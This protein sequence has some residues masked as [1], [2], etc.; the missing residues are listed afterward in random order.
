MVY[1]S[2]TLYL[3]L[4]AALLM[5]VVLFDAERLL[6]DTPEELR[7]RPAWYALILIGFVKETTIPFLL[8][9]LLCRLAGR[10]RGLRIALRSGRTL[11]AEAGVV[12]GVLFPL[13]AYLFFRELWAESSAYV[14]V[15][16]HLLDPRNYTILLRSYAQ[17][18]GPLGLL[19][20]GGLIVMLVRRRFLV[21]LFLATAFFGDA[22]FHFL[23]QVQLIG[24]SRFNLL[25]FPWWWWREHTPLT[26]YRAGFGPPRLC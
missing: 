25:F 7:V 4:P 24:Y 1:Y 14:A 20:A 5:T 23:D 6:T 12:F 22:A 9:F 2:S 21:V 18:F 3:E 19:A 11:L 16:V 13:A 10:A 8:A 17:Q 26:P 15:P